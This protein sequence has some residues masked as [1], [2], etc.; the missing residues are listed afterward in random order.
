M[1]KSALVAA[2]VL[3]LAAPA[4]AAAPRATASATVGGHQ[5]AIEYGRP[6]LKGRSFDELAKQLPADRMWRAGSEQVTTFTCAG[7]VLVGGKKVPAGKYSL[8]VHAPAEGNHSLVLNKDLGIALGKIWAKAPENMKNEP[9]PHVDDYTAA[10]GSQEVA[11]VALK[12]GTPKQP[13]DLFTITLDPTKTGATLT[14]S[15]G[16]HSWSLDL[17][18]AK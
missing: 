17:G 8:Y 3:A 1:H 5:V 2:T 15:W 11:R 16:A 4:F 9:W 18:A 14:L 13:E 7:D 12:K 6:A 10:I